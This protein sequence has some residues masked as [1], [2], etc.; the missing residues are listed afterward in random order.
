[1]LPPWG[2]YYLG[3]QKASAHFGADANSLLSWSSVVAFHILR[4]YADFLVIPKCVSLPKPMALGFVA[5]S[6]RCCCILLDHSLFNWSCA[7]AIWA[8]SATYD[9]VQFQVSRI[10]DV[11]GRAH[12]PF[13]TPFTPPTCCWTLCRADPNVRELAPTYSNQGNSR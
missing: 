2:H 4:P 1:M 7:F 11:I 3:S 12:T 6:S 13:S 9:K 8:L 5:F 10:R